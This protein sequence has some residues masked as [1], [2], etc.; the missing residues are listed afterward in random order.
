M[1]SHAL[2]LKQLYN[3]YTK[4]A[5]TNFFRDCG[6]VFMQFMQNFTTFFGCQIVQPLTVFNPGQGVL[7]EGWVGGGSGGVMV[8]GEESNIV[9]PRLTKLDTLSKPNIYRCTLK[10]SLL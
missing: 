3:L 6:C 2:I 7:S 1:C 9:N 4:H 10:I 5:I 8:N